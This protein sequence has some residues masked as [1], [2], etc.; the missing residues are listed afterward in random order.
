MKKAGV[1]K[2][3]CQHRDRDGRVTLVPSALDTSIK[4]PQTPS[5]VACDPRSYRDFR[6]QRGGR[7][8][9]HAKER[10]ARQRAR[11]SGILKVARCQDNGTVLRPKLS[12][13]RNLAAATHTHTHTHT[14]YTHGTHTLNDTLVQHR[15]PTHDIKWSKISAAIVLAEW[16]IGFGDDVP[17]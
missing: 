10:G 7:S 12:Q 16:Q 17:R 8:K 5:Q 13:S 14:V 4:M 3:R 11:K 2:F 1:G 6:A 15:L 9:E